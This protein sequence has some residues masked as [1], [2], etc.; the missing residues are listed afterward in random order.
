MK[1]KKLVYKICNFLVK[2]FIVWTYVRNILK[3]IFSTKKTILKNIEYVI[4]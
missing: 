3:L 1:I 2:T 4:T